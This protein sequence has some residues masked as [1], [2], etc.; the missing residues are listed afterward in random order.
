MAY[1]AIALAFLGFLIGL[2]FRLV[3][4]LEFLGGILLLSIGISFGYRLGSVET[5]LTVTAIQAIV[6]CGYFVGLLARVLFESRHT[7]MIL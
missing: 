3:V 1:T 5:F 6:Q 2:R 7:R 4:L